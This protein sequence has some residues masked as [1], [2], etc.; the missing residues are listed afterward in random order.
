MAVMQY[1]RAIT[2][3]KDVQSV[4]ALDSC[5][6]EPGAEAEPA[7]LGA[8]LV[9]LADLVLEYAA[10]REQRIWALQLDLRDLS[11]SLSDCHAKGQD[12]QLHSLLVRNHTSQCYQATPII[13]V[14]MAGYAYIVVLANGCCRIMSMPFMRMLAH[15]LSVG[16]QDSQRAVIADVTKKNSSLLSSASQLK[17]EN[18]RLSERLRLLRASMECQGQQLPAGTDTES[19]ALNANPLLRQ[20]STLT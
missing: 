6:A 15:N 3:D 20:V 1:K 19:R 17:D 14:R 8:E 5:S 16:L 7:A 11:T 2:R 10:E 9:H 12:R 13:A 4:L 18:V